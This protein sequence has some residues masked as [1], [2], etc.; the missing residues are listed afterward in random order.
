M[1]STTASP[2]ILDGTASC[3]SCAFFAA[4]ENDDHNPDECRLLPPTVTAHSGKTEWPQVGPGGWCGHY[5]PDRET[6][7]DL[8]IV[9]KMEDGTYVTGLP[10]PK[11][12][13]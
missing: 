3:D 2:F 12:D 5:R 6:E 1:K 10:K 11:A 13:D 7:I 4:A 8:G 9:T